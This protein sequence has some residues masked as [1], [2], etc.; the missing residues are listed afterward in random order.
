MS[1]TADSYGW[2]GGFGT[3]WANDDPAEERS[4]ILMA[5]R[6]QYP[7]FS[8]IYLDFRTTAYQAIDD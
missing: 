4:V 8:P 7:A 3:A 6:A 5:Q 2:N 1:T